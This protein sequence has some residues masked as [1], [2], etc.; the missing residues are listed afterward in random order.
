[1]GREVCAL[2]YALAQHG[3]VLL[4]AVC[5]SVMPLRVRVCARALAQEISIP[6]LMETANRGT[7]K[8]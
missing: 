3:V 2:S 8:M 1:M 4:V 7:N 5:G 6:S